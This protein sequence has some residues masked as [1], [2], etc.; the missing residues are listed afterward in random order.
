VRKITQKEVGQS[1]LGALEIYMDEVSGRLNTDKRG[2]Y[3]GGFDTGD[4]IFVL[5]KDGSYELTDY[6]LTNR[7]ETKEI[8]EIRKFDPD[9]TVSAVYYEGGKKWTMVKRFKVETTSQ[10]QRFEFVTDNRYTKLLYASTKDKPIIKYSYR[11]KN[12][13]IETELNIPKFIDVK[14]WK[15][16]GNKLVDQKITGVKDVTPKPKTKSASKKLKAGDSIDFEI[17]NGQTKMF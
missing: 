12:N 6:E 16:M 7:Y 3:L 14:G 10:G 1:T 8:T 5:Y 11:E 17:D 15:A 2:Q 4:Q 9:L 13:K